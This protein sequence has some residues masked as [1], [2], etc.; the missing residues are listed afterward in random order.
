MSKIRSFFSMIMTALK[1][2]NF[3]NEHVHPIVGWRCP[4]VARLA[5]V[6]ITKR[7]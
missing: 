5:T 6:K 2:L 1:S 4:P 7:L 3:E